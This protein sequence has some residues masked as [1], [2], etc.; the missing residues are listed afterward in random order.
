MKMTRT[1]PK[2]KRQVSGIHLRYR[3]KRRRLDV[4]IDLYAVAYYIAVLWLLFGSSF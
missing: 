1:F 2:G 3:D 4:R